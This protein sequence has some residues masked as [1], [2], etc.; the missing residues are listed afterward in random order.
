[1]WSWPWSLETLLLRSQFLKCGLIFD[2]VHCICQKK[3]VFYPL[4]DLLSVCPNH[5]VEPLGPPPHLGPPH[6]IPPPTA[7]AGKIMFKTEIFAC[8]CATFTDLHCI[9]S[10]TAPTYLSQINLVNVSLGARHPHLR[11][12]SPPSWI[13]A[14]LEQVRLTD[15]YPFFEPLFE[16]ALAR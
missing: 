8:G 14:N 13:R 15:A 7:A 16:E 9:W 11:S 3:L 1:M 10:K 6:H 12:E 2:K 5:V 4:S